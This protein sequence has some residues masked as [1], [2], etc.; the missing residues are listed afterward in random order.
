MM[1]LVSQKIRHI[2][3]RGMT[4]AIVALGMTA[5]LF[6][7]FSRMTDDASGRLYYSDRHIEN[8]ANKLEF[9]S[10]GSIIV[11]STEDE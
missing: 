10:P 7:F 4:V 3:P 1:D 11:L 8:S 9:G 6:F 5:T 2:P